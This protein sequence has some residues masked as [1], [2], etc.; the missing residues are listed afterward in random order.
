MRLDLLTA[1]RQLRRAP[2]TS[3]ASV[4]TLGVGIGATTSVIAFLLAVMSTATPVDDMS[5]LVAL[6]SHNRA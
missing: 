4:V 6:W 2:G 5:R 1:L 3:I